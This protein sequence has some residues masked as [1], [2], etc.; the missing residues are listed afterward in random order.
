MSLE[1]RRCPVPYYPERNQA[2]AYWPWRDIIKEERRALA[3]RDQLPKCTVC[4]QALML[5]QQAAHFSCLR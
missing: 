4:G 5:R 1:F 3:H 2:I